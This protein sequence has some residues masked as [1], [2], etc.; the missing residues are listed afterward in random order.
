MGKPKLKLVKQS[1]EIMERGRLC[2]NCY[3]DQSSLSCIANKVNCSQ[4]KDMISWIVVEDKG[5]K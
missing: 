1:K 5:N 3:Y 2:T 4:K